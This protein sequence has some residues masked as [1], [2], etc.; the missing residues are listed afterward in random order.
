MAGKNGKQ[1]RK[2]WYEMQLVNPEGTYTVRKVASRAK[3]REM[4][5]VESPP[6]EAARRQFRLNELN[7][8][9]VSLTKQHSDE[10]VPEKKAELGNRLEWAKQSLLEFKSFYAEELAASVGQAVT[11]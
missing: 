11:A 10:K 4:W 2:V 3:G 5:F 8:Q 6:R 9:I 1:R 7:N